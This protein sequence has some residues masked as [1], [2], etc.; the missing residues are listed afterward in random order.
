MV[1]GIN[2]YSAGAL[3]L[4]QLEYIIG[5][6]AFARGMK[7]Y[8]NAWQFKHPT[9]YDFLRIMDAKSD[10]ELGLVL[11]LLQGSSKIY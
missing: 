4:N 7:R 2:S 1:Y 11:K 8:W 9:P 10:L 3:F 5:E 6:E